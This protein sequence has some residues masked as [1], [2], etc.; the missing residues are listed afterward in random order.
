MNTGTGWVSASTRSHGN[1]QPRSGYRYEHPDYYDSAVGRNDVELIGRRTS[2]G[3]QVRYLGGRKGDSVTVREYAMEPSQTPGGGYATSFR[4]WYLRR[5]EGKEAMAVDDYELE[6][7]RDPH[8]NTIQRMM[9]PI[10]LN[11]LSAFGMDL[12]RHLKP[13][14]RIMLIDSIIIMPCFIVVTRCR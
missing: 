3:N 11:L 2:G 8:D 10:V 12:W 1:A 7:T 13:F 5:L 9:Q 6:V 4:P 14:S